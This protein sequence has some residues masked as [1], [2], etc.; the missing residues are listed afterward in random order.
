VIQ[1]KFDRAIHIKN[2]E[3]VHIETN[4]KHG[5]IDAKG[6]WVIQ[7]KF[8]DLWFFRTHELAPAKSNGK[9]GYVDAKGSWVIQPK[10]PLNKWAVQRCFCS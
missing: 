4:G 9:W 3:L 2:S 8:D 6:A 5:I 10:E 1:P 7:P